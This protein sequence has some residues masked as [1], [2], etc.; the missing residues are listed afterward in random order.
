MGKILEMP[1]TD[2]LSSYLIG[3][4]K[5]LEQKMREAEQLVWPDFKSYMRK[6]R[7]SSMKLVWS[8]LC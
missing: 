4:M 8:V 7:R 6:L 5:F 2:F 1:N 3:L